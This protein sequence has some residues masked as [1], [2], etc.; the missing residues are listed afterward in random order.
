[1]RKKKNKNNILSLKKNSDMALDYQKNLAD[2]YGKI[3]HEIDY[4]YSFG[5][6]NHK[7]GNENNRVKEYLFL[8]I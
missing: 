2:N 5:N 4:T 8:G 7:I 1:M 6:Q 3:V